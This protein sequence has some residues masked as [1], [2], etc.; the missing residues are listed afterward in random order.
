MKLKEYIKQ[1]C[2]E[3]SKNEIYFNVGVEPNMEVNDKSPNRI[4]FTLIRETE[5]SWTQLQ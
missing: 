2:Q 3:S 5:R 1:K 4:K